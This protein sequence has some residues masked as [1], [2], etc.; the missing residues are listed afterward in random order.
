[1]FDRTLT[2]CH[3]DSPKSQQSLRLKRLR[4]TN[5]PGRIGMLT[6]EFDSCPRAL[7]SLQPVLSCCSRL[8]WGR[9]QPSAKTQH[10]LLLSPLRNSHPEVVR[11]G[12]FAEN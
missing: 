7:Q 5:V 6:Q 4:S 8:P 3:A 12:N 9:L 10:Q 1:M 11:C 2:K